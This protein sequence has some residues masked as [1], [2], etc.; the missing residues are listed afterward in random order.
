MSTEKVRFEA[1]VTAEAV[2][3][4][5]FG[6]AGANSVDCTDA[7]ALEVNGVE[8]GNVYLTREAAEYLMYS[9]WSAG[10]EVP[11]EAKA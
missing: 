1:P 9:L 11:E 6:Y 5:K 2:A 3:K 4:L 10:V 7:V 8:D